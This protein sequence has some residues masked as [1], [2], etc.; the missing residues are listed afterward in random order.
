VG[1]ESPP[2]VANA[3]QMSVGVSGEALG[4]T[5]DSLLESR[6]GVNLTS[7]FGILE[8]RLGPASHESSAPLFDVLGGGPVGE[9]G[10]SL[11]HPISGS[12]VRS[13]V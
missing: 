13:L 4:W 11:C 12:E 1:E 8:L 10:V 5:Q 3:Q 9:E 7:G 2:M 6:A